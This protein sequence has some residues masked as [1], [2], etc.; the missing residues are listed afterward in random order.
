MPNYNKSCVYK[1]CCKDPKIKEEYIGSTTNFGR[2][3]CQHKTMCNN[4]KDRRYNLYV[5]KY[6]N[7]VTVSAS[8][9]DKK[10]DK[11]CGQS[12]VERCSLT[13]FAV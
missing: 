8:N 11:R 6:I 1:L 2:R 12:Y 9:R 3:K 10:R 13:I 5:Y 4:E 7:A